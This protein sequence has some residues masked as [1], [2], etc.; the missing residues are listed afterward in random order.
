[1]IPQRD[2]KRVNDPFDYNDSHHVSRLN[3]IASQWFRKTLAKKAHERGSFLQDDENEWLWWWHNERYWELIEA[4]P[5]LRNVTTASDWQ[6]A[7]LRWPMRIDIGRLTRDF[8]HRFTQQTHLT[9]MNGKPRQE[10]ASRALNARRRRVPDICNDFGHPFSQPHPVK[11][12]ENTKAEHSPSVSDD[13]DDGDDNEP[14][15]AKPKTP[16]KPKPPPKKTGKGEKG[17][18]KA[19]EDVDDEEEPDGGEADGESDDQPVRKSTRHQ[20][21]RLDQAQAS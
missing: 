8:N 5:Q 17:K 20:G 18:K 10:R 16:K 14:K 3:A 2:E 19:N 12:P 11:E 13:G 4:H 21:G 15:V 9:G 6:R 7:G 1:M